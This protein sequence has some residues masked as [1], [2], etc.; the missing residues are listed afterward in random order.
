MNETRTVDD[1]IVV[2]EQDVTNF[3]DRIK[4]LI[5]AGYQPTGPVSTFKK[6]LNPI[7]N[8][9]FDRLCHDRSFEFAKI[10]RTPTTVYWQQMTHY[11]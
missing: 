11:S 2:E 3:N 1:L 6:L 8:M 5:K 9:E 4:L 7:S 10:M